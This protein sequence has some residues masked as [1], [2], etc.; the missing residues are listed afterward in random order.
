MGLQAY[1]AH[2]FDA[3]IPPGSIIES[4]VMTVEARDTSAAGSITI[5][6]TAHDRDTFDG[7]PLIAP[8]ST[9]N[10]WRQDRWSNQSM[11]VLSTTFTAIGSGA[12]RAANASWI[13]KQ[14]GTWREQMA[15]Q[16][17]TRT[18]NMEVDFVFYEML[19]NGN[20]AGSARVRIQGVT[21]HKGRDIPDG[22]DI[23]V[24]NDVLLSTIAL[25]PTI[26]TI[27]FTFAVNPTLVAL[28]D[29]FFIIEVDYTANNA[30]YVS[31]RHHNAFLNN[32]R[33]YHKGEDTAGGWQNY[34]GPYDWLRGSLGLNSGIPLLATVDWVV[35]QFIA[36][37]T[38]K[39]PDIS[40]IV[41]AQV[42]APWYT[43]DSGI[44]TGQQAPQSGL[45]NRNWKS[46]AF[47]LVDRPRLIVTYGGRRVMVT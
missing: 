32:G 5:P 1:S 7:E 34:P 21:Q 14:I 22:V 30:D 36:N 31:V 40:A 38:Y 47:A 25:A 33:L 19:R 42:N 3:Q 13:M 6:I 15:Q 37:V 23:A 44:I 41:Q 8:Y 18:G 10:N 29:Y 28:T 45:A 26:S 39:T 4:A 16:V 24:S 35:P 46:A 12:T 20:P 11:G 9:F 27:G 2:I 17:T 43:I